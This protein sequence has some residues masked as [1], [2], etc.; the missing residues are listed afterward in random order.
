MKNKFGKGVREVARKTIGK[1]YNKTVQAIKNPEESTERA[2]WQRRLDDAKS[3]YSGE[4]EKMNLN[5]AYYN[6]TR[7]V[8]GNP[9]SNK[10]SNKVASNVWNITYELIESQVD[11][12]IPYPKVTAIHAEDMEKAKMIE[13]ALIN[14]VRNLKLASMN[15]L[16]ERTTPVMGADYMHVEWDN[17]KGYHSTVGGVSVSSRSPKQIIPQPGVTCIEDMDY[18]FVL[19]THTKKSVKKKYGVDVELA[20]EESPE[21]R[22]AGAPTNE[23]LVTVNSCYY[24]NDEGNIGIFTWCDDYV[25]E[26]IYDY[27]SRQMERCKKCGE[28]RD[29]DECKCGSKTFEMVPEKMQTLTKDIETDA[30]SIK[31]IKVEEV[32]EIDPMT[33]ETI[34]VEQE[35]PVEIPYYQPNCIPIV[36]RKNVSKANRLIGVS[37]IDVIRDQQDNVKKL[38]SK[39]SEKV[40]GGGSMITLPK[41]VNITLDD[42]E[43]KVV[44]I[45]NP[46]DLQMIKA[47]D[48]KPDVTVDRVLIND[49]YQR[50]K[51]SL[52]ITDSFQGK[53]DASATSGVSKQYAINQAAG[54]LESKKAM[55]ND[56]YAKLYEM[57]F[58]FWLAYA[59]QKIPFQSIGQNGE[60]EFDYFDRFQFLKEDDAGEWYWNDEFIFETDPTSTIMSNREAMWQ[61]I[62]FKLQSGAFGT[63]GDPSTNLKYWKYME[64]NGYPNAGEIKKDFELEV[65]QKQEQEQT[66]LQ[67]QMQPQ[68][69]QMEQPQQAMM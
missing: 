42:T 37:D 11:P 33:G 52:G 59:D 51:S 3:Q 66:L 1:A 31:A 14:E 29:G 26:N 47:I 54:R 25:L 63:L 17:E 23:D 30:V 32:E 58:K 9:N 19:T 41:S 22:G 2:K 49:E 55:K 45:S 36:I 35:I 28:P 64:K 21:L 48:L 4:I 5:E 50:A 27:Q 68:E 53:Y 69:G 61:Q 24:R 62:D 20:V 34:L 8:Q 12:S 65:Q 7:E 39:I 18:I 6:G 46:A 13:K 10:R 38:G 16:Q 15:D 60:Q 67:M 56:A 57:I 43:M 40:Y 44:R